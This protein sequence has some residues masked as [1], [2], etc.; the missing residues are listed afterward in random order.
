MGHPP[1]VRR[2]IARDA[3]LAQFGEL[4]RSLQ[5]CAHV[6]SGEP[7]V[8]PANHFARAKIP[9][10]QQQLKVL[11]GDVRPPSGLNFNTASSLAKAKLRLPAPHGLDDP[12]RLQNASFSNDF[13]EPGLQLGN[14]T[15]RLALSFSRNFVSSQ[16]AP[17]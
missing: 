16:K 10:L 2:G 17:N 7:P 6:T 4:A 12:Q 13:H 14:A 1:C 11:S 15:K 5:L 9:Q 8:R 3:C